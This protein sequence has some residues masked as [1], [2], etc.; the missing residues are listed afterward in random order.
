MA[1]LTEIS[2][3]LRRRGFN[4]GQGDSGSVYQAP[5]FQDL[6]W[7]KFSGGTEKPA[8]YLSLDRKLVLVNGDDPAMKP[9]HDRIRLALSEDNLDVK[10]EEW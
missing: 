4:L 8:G 5:G 2:G 10:I 6:A 9:Y 7:P 1:T 3:S